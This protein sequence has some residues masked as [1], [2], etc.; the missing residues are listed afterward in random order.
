MVNIKL[1][2]VGGFVKGGVVVCSFKE[3]VINYIKKI[4]ANLFLTE[5]VHF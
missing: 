3:C 4:S 1:C 5:L 2:V